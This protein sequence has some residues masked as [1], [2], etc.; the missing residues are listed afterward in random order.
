MLPSVTIET[1][2][3]LQEV[4]HL[5]INFKFEFLL[6]MYLLIKLVI[7]LISTCQKTGKFWNVGE[8]RDG[9]NKLDWKS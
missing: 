1:E 7:T 6:H 3:D 8:E 9:E 4:T 5:N 2:Q